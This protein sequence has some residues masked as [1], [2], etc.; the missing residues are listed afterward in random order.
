MKRFAISLLCLFS[1]IGVDHTF[2]QEVLFSDG[3]E[4][5]ELDPAF[6]EA[7]PGTPAGVVEVISND[8][9]P[10]SGIFG[11]RLGKSVDGDATTNSLD[12]TLDLSGREQVE[13][14]FW[15]RSNN[16]AT[17]PQDGLWFSDDGGQTFT[18][19]FD[20]DLSN[21]TQGT[22]GQFPPFDVDLLASEN[23][24]SLTNQFVIRFQQHGDRDFTG[25]ASGR[26]GIY[27]DDVSVSAGP[28]TY[29]ALPFE[30]G[31][32][33]GMLGNS[34][35]WGDSRTSL[36]SGFLL[37]GGIVGIDS[38]SAANTGIFGVVM[39]RR[40]DGNET[41]NALD[42]HL[43]L[44]QHEQVE[45][46]FV[47]FSNNDE[48]NLRGDGI[49]FSDDG[50]STFRKVFEYDL[51][52]GAWSEHVVPIDALAAEAG[53]TLSD[54]FIIR[55]QQHGDRDFTGVASGR[56]GI[57]L[58][59]VSVSGTFVPPGM[60]DGLTATITGTHGNDV[61]TG[62]LGDDVIDGLGGNDVICAGKGIDIV[63]GGDGN[64]EHLFRRTGG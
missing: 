47:A 52:S 32:E 48:P 15:V 19:V 25:V 27:L 4:S 62:T 53:M 24:L 35:R 23:G 44:L 28:V 2:A 39:G 61:I 31:F 11:V 30:D 33:E 46:R 51:T 50:G 13:L 45:L 6:W 55:F 26:D 12:L 57:Y 7:R 63:F 1:V 37:P 58:D 21:W 10:Q 14:S 42:L 34:W 36:P 56:D 5:G 20:F 29:S 64:E 38:D 54:Q 49:W 59:D 18:K 41:T 8:D 22:Y 40:T 16:D 17:N 9:V 43:D 3:F 60:C